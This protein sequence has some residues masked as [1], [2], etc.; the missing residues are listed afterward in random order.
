MP[1]VLGTAAAQAGPGDHI[2]TGDTTIIPDIDLGV[3]YRTN[4]YRAP[5]DPTAGTNLRIAP[6]LELGV[7]NPDNAFAL[8]GEWQVR[9]YLFLAVEDPDIRADAI[10]AVDR[11]N[12]FNVGADLEVLK[13]ES[14]GLKLTER[15]TLRNNATDRGVL[16]NPFVTQVRNALGGGL[17]ISPGQALHITPGVEWAYDDFRVADSEPFRTRFNSRNTYGPT[18]A[19][20]WDFFPRTGF[21]LYGSG[22]WHAWSES[23][24]AVVDPSTG[25][26][27]SLAIPD[28]THIKVLT[29]LEGRFTERIFVD[30]LFG[31]G[32]ALY[33]ASAT[34]VIDEAVADL[35][36]AEG[37]IG[38]I[39]TR[40]KLIREDEASAEVAVGFKRDFEDS[41]FTNYVS[42][43]NVYGSAGFSV[44]GFRPRIKHTIR[45]EDYSGAVVRNDVLN[46]F[47]SEIAYGFND[48]GEVSGGFFWQQRG[49]VQTNLKNAEY[50][51]FT[52]RLNSTWTY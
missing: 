12:D 38:S 26:G 41:F 30:L 44:G 16:G 19:A 25:V 34:G 22:S 15:V 13:Q 9:K 27:G 40:Y 49:I 17:R 31:Y 8:S 29:G 11:F 37:L 3:E 33:Q 39:Q 2:R 24:V 28:S 42:Y 47:E 21:V 51:D 46:R 48:W 35:K 18:L 5:S 7:E 1:F 45:F 4:T 52:F 43:N 6:G 20:R 14:V 36:G 32:N 50:D 10:R 23:E